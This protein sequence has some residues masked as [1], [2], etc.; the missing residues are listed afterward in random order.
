MKK[1]IIIMASL[2]LTTTLFAEN[3]AD[4]RVVPLPE[5]IVMVNKTPFLLSSQT[6]IVVPPGNEDL[7][8]DGKFLAEYIG[9]TTG[10][11]L[12]VTS[13]KSKNAIHLDLNKKITN[14]EG[15]TLLVEI[16]RAHV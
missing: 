9:E 10:I 7:F 12:S 6:A 8:R 3:K 13:V 4:Y 1:I 16:G 5:S 15:Y 2:L 14:K 11:R